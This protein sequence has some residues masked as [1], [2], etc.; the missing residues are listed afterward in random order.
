MRRSSVLAAFCA[1]SVLGFLA[2]SPAAPVSAAARHRLPGLQAGARLLA[3]RNGVT[4]IEASTSH[5][6]FFLQGWVHARD[7]LFQMDLTRRQASGT[8]AELLGK[9]AL[10]ATCRRAR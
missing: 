4:H 3:D 10:R 2:V 6:L 1:L 9:A 7:R 8:L 5:D